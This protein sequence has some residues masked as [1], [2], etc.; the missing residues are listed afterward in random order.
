MRYNI[1]LL[2]STIF[3]VYY[4]YKIKEDFVIMF[5]L[6]I[7][8]LLRPRLAIFAVR[9]H[10]KLIAFPVQIRNKNFDGYY[11][12]HSVI[13]ATLPINSF[14]LLNLAPYLSSNYQLRCIL[15]GKQASRW[16]AF[17]LYFIY[18]YPSALNVDNFRFLWKI[19]QLPIKKWKYI[20]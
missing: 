7:R 15:V 4:M 18:F 10:Y 11:L 5:L 8:L 16:L 13:S 17:S 1:F 20:H 6:C 2:Y 9:L 12:L 3:I 19:N 14:Y